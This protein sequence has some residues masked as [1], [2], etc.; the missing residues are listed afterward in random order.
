MNRESLRQKI[1]Q[2]KATVCV[3]GLG[4]VGLPLARAILKNGF[5]V[6]GLDTDPDKTQQLNRGASYL[7]AV[8]DAFVEQHVRDDT[9]RPTTDTNA[10][11]E[12]DIVLICVPTPLKDDQ[13][14]NTE[15]IEQTAQTI[16]EHLQE[17]QLIVLESTTYPGTTEELLVPLLEEGGLE[18]GT[19]FFVAYSPER[20]DPGNNEYT[21]ENIPKVVGGIDDTSSL[22]AR[23]FYQH[24]TVG[25]VSV[26]GPR[27]AEA[28]KLLENIYRSVNIALVNEFKTI[29]QN[30]DVDVWDVIEAA[31]T[32]PFGYEPFYPGPG[33]GGHCLPIDPFYLS[34][35]AE[36]TGQE[37]RM[38][39]LAGQINASMPGQIV[40]QIKRTLKERGKDLSDTSGLLLGAAYKKDVNDTRVSPSFKFFQLLEDQGATV[41]YHDPHVPKIKGSRDYPGEKTSV[42][43]YPEVLSDYDFVLITTDHS[44]Y[45]PDDIIQHAP[46]I[47]DSRNLTGE[48]GRE[49]DHVIF[50]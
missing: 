14:P 19:D 50:V 18:A 3:I 35:K 48:R 6:I 34:W 2:K 38:V 28:T 15:Y 47:F 37:A 9:F 11:R 17:D 49:Q 30:M 39:D 10:L 1:E 46:L 22:L 12:A 16:R 33:L 36:Q 27:E 4:Y 7:D 23:E 21:T 43:G 32:K 13:T 45:Q 44:S 20:Q 31:S 25:V 29:F 40:Q 41:D 8:S 42:D 26:D 24:I 5:P